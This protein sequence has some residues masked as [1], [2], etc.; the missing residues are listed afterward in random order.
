MK[1]RTCEGKKSPILTD[2][3]K[4]LDCPSAGS[5]MTQDLGSD[6]VFMIKYSV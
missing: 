6:P 2:R 3:T 1:G 5:I 4:V